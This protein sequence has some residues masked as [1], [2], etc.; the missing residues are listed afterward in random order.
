MEEYKSNSHASKR[1][2]EAEKKQE[3]KKQAEKVTT[4]AVKTKKKTGFRKFADDFI[5]EDAKS[6]KSY[7]FTDV[8]LPAA[9]K[10]V[11]DIFT[12]G[13]DMILYGGKGG[14]KR[15]QAGSKI[16]YRSYYDDPRNDDRRV[17][18]STRNRYD[19]DDIIF[20]S[21][22]DAEAVLDQM[23]EILERY[24]MVTVA[25]MYDAAGLSAPYTSNR[26]GWLN[27]HNAQVRRIMGGEFVLDL[28]KASPLD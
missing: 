24:K 18:A 21:R 27:L 13:I 6:V 12:E 15:K 7:I 14:G 1:A 20:N 2:A 26:Y 17:T 3:E 4:G 10:A 19:F 28:P 25:D 16:S 8:L 23:N 5:A 11:Y 22:G 9:K